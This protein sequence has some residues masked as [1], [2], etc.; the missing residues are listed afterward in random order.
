MSPW[1]QEQELA[2]VRK[3]LTGKTA[4]YDR[5]VSILR[6]MPQEQTVPHDVAMR[7][8]SLAMSVDRSVVEEYKRKVGAK[9]D[10]DV[11][12]FGATAGYLL[13]IAEVLYRKEAWSS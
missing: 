2:V 5:T 12:F 13:K 10:S 11:K 8:L 6:A 4:S 9:K 7:L 1:S 3:W